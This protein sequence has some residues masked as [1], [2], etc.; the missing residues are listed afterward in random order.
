M[1]CDIIIPIWNKL[2]LTRQCI[3][4]IAR[5]TRFPYRIIAVDNASDKDTKEYLEGLKEDSRFDFLLIRNEENLGNTKA[6]NQGMDASDAEYVCILDNDTIVMAGW[7][8]EMIDIAES[9]KDIGIVNPSNNFG[10]KKPWRQTYEDYA[11]QRTRNNRGKFNETASPVGFCYLIKRELLDRIGKWDE[12]F[13]PGYF[14]DTEYAL[15]AREAGYKSVFAKGAFV[16]H[17]EHSSFKSRKKGFTTL[18]KQ[19][20]EKF[21]GRF[22]RP[23]RILYVLSEGSDRLY[24][25]IKTE[26]YQQASDSNWVWV[27]LKRSAPDIALSDHSY[28][29]KFLLFDLLFGLNVIFRVLK[30]KKKFSRIIVDEARLQKRLERLGNFHKAKVQLI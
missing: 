11:L 23:E 16:W 4:Y 28:I 18:F 5:N 26:S 27:F 20:E 24:E 3:D 15:R 12:S 7:L 21:Y 14:E 1:K 8:G 2:K 17:I 6:A 30:R 29:R 10:K 19:S 25:R 13:S 9:A 22:K